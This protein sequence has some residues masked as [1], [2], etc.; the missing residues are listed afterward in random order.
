MYAITE[1]QKLGGLK[2]VTHHAEDSRSLNS[3]KTVG[4]SNLEKF[5][6]FVALSQLS[7]VPF[8]LYRMILNLSPLFQHMLCVH[9]C[10]IL[11]FFFFFLRT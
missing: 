11:C 6:F 1:A 3:P 8:D 5:S 4:A 10:E 2:E 7:W 9:V